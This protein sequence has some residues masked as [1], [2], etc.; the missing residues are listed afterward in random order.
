MIQVLICTHERMAKGIKKT[1]EFIMGS[2]PNLHEVSAYTE[3]HPN[4]KEE[5][6]NILLKYANEPVVVFTDIIGGSVNTELT[7]MTVN[8]PNLHII[9]GVNL[10]MVIQILLSNESNL[11][12]TIEKTIAEGK[13]GIQYVNRSLN[14]KESELEDDF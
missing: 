12:A 7:Q 1:V 6:E 14:G 9:S 8:Y 10:P 3:E 5:V 2:Q 4:H 11:E 13:N